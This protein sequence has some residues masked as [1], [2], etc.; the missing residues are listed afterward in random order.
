M[1]NA[2]TRRY[3]AGDVEFLHQGS[4]FSSLLLMR[5]F[6][7]EYPTKP[8]TFSLQRKT[9]TSTRTPVGRT[10]VPT[11]FAQSSPRCR[12][13]FERH[14]MISHPPKLRLTRQR[15]IPQSSALVK[16]AIAQSDHLIS[17]Q[18]Q[19]CL[20]TSRSLHTF[21][22]LFAL[23]PPDLVSTFYA[24]HHAKLPCRSTCARGG[25]GPQVVFRRICCA[26]LR[27]GSG[28]A[29]EKKEPY[30][31]TLQAC[32]YRSSSASADHGLRHRSPSRLFQ[33]SS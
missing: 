17:A 24:R 14:R 5:Y 15:N 4:D 10:K 22:L 23:L 31:Q 33:N 13:P 29:D 2:Q 12:S 27:A 19:C 11:S 3:G 6:L 8:V 26:N 28:S 18:Q 30:R 32:E 9:T 1:L 20:T 21:S 25:D 16:R 7:I